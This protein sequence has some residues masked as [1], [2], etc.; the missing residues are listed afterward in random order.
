[1]S[2]KDLCT[3]E[4]L[5]EMMDVIDGFK[6]EGRSK[7]EMYVGAITKAYRHVCDALNAHTPIDPTLKE[8]V[9]QI[10]HRQYRDGFLFNDI[11]SAPDGKVSTPTEDDVT[12]NAYGGAGD[13]VTNQGVS[14]SSP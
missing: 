3:I 10:P 12:L 11:R 4:R 5:D 8:L 6:I 14:Q 9:Y 7:S 13:D 2:S 1:M